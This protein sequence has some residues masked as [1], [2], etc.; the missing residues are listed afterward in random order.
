MKIKRILIQQKIF[1]KQFLCLHKIQTLNILLQKPFFF[2]NFKTLCPR[3]GRGGR[4]DSMSAYYVVGLPIESR[5][6]TSATYVA[7]RECDWLP[8]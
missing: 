7:C 6:P 1:L 4:V 5:Q 8:C 3:A 2:Q